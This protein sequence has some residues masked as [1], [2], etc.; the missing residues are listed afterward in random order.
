MSMRDPTDSSRHVVVAASQ[1]DFN[2]LPLAV[3]I[4]VWCWC[5][6]IRILLLLLLQILGF[7]LM[8][9]IFLRAGSKGSF[10]GPDRTYFGR[11][12]GGPRQYGRRIARELV[13]Y[14]AARVIIP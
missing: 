11:Y 5:R 13:R 1:S 10:G 12:L 2:R 6:Q 14:L 3:R 9:L 7:S 4:A 8:R